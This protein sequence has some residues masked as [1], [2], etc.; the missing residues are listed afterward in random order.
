M[1]KF[2]RKIRKELIA[3]KKVSNYILYAIGEI[4]L[5][6]IGILI[7]LAINNANEN[8]VKREK[9]QIY[10]MGL[11]DEFQT[12]RVKLNELIAYNKRSYEEAKKIVSYMDTDS[13]PS[14]QELSNLFFN[15]FAFD[16]AFIPNN[17]LLNEMINS[18]SLKDIKNPQLR[19]LL[20]NWIATIDDTSKQENLLTNERDKII[21]M[22]RSNENSIRTIYDLTGVSGD[23]GLK[24]KNE[25]LSNI[26]LLNSIEFENNILTFILTSQQTETVKYM[27]LMQ[28]LDA[29]LALLDKEI[30]Q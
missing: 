9:E 28:S 21:N 18:G 24:E 4:V 10:L 15:A 8:H 20:T 7:A 17:S 22:F 27:P 5:V 2:F 19:I 3:E 1:L 25:H 23:L 14:E 16:I 6:V 11:K 26:P 13:L 30:E 12:S 29:I